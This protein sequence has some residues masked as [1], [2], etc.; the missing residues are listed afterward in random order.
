MDARI[1]HIEINFHF[2]CDLITQQEL[3]MYF[4]YIKEQVTNALNK[5]L[6]I[7]CYEFL[8]HKL[9]VLVEP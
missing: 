8:K 1:K 4:V 2:V 5:G 3:D 9:L 7:A 6:S